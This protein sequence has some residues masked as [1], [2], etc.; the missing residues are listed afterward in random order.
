MYLSLNWH[1]SPVCLNRKSRILSMPR[2]RHLPDDHDPPFFT[3]R[4][5]MKRCPQVLLDL[6]WNITSWWDVYP[7][8]ED[9]A[10][11]DEEWIPR[12]VASG[13]FILSQDDAMR[14]SPTIC[15]VIINNEAHV[16]ALSRADLTGPGKANRFH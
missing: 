16:F 5:L 6:G 13:F 14:E 10:I 12:A 7:E 11:D 4:S 9:N 1:L 2:A 3:D 15:D 8:E